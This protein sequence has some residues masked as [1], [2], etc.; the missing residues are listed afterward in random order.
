MNLTAV[1]KIVL[2]AIALIG[3]NALAFVYDAEYI[4]LAI[5]IDALVLGVELKGVTSSK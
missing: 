3:I 2:E 5:G 1:K 4:P